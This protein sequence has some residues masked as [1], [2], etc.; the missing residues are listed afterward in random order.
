MKAIILAAGAS[1]RMIEMT[2]DRPKCLLQLGNKSVL[3]HQIDCLHGNSITDVVVVTGFCGDRIRER[4]GDQATYV[5]NPVYETTNSL[6]S[7]WL[8][9][10][11]AREGFV[12]LNS[13]VFFHPQ[14][15]ERLLASPHPDALLV[16]FDDNLG[17]EEMKVKARNG[18]VID[19]SKEMDGRDADGENVGIV[20]FSPDGS[21]V[22]FEKIE[23][24]VKSGVVHAWAPFAFQKICSYHAL[25]V[26][27]TGGLPWIEM[28]FVEDFERAR[29]EIYPQIF[30][31]DTT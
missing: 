6:Y 24:L 31:G 25:Y 26:V 30:G 29:D 27:S 8:A 11:E 4:L 1:K 10:E 17:E 15:L 2:R 16:S 9:R 28:D 18:R 22:L 3:E 20:K 12:V 23:E 19:I 5:A 21:T 7:L 14:M 13:D